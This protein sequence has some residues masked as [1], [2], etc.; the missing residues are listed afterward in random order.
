[1]TA[2]R[3]CFACFL[4]L[5]PIALAHAADANLGGVWTLVPKESDDP[6]KALKGLGIVRLTQRYSTDDRPTSRRDAEQSRYY[7]QQNML[8]AKRA[9]GATANVGLINHMLA[10]TKLVIADQGATVDLSFDDALRRSLKPSS[11][12]P[13][14]SAKGA[15][16]TRDPM[17]QTL[18]WRQDGV[19]QVETI[20][21]PRGKM[22]ESFKIDPAKG[23]LVINTVIENPDWIIPAKL[24]RVF[25]PAKAP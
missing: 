20:L 7:Q 5:L 3:A 14:Y 12:G 25:E 15:E 19:L 2:L 9:A 24:R 16:Y 8:D 18:S 11:G 23:R 21:E 10:A 4:L 22:T 13:V 1:M 6:E 17:G